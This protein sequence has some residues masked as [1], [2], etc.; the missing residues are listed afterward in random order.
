VRP[1][2]VKGRRGGSGGDV[3]ERGES[4]CGRGGE[5][6]RAEKNFG[7][8]R[9]HLEVSCGVENSTRPSLIRNRMAHDFLMT[10]I[11]LLIPFWSCF[12]I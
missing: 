3:C 2:A 7:R 9:K 11:A 1:T 6:D 12:N 8:G 5:G 4:G 10:W